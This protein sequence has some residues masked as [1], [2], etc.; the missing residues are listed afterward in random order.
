MVPLVFIGADCATLGAMGVT[1]SGAQAYCSKLSSTGDD[2]WSLYPSQ[3][4]APSS[5]PGPTD[6]VYPPGIEQQVQVCV[7][8]TRQTRLKCR[9]DVREGNISGPM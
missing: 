6:E 1:E 7:D 5:T 4:P 8:E 2:V 3:V 9:E